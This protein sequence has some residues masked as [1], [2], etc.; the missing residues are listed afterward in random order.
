MAVE[1][2]QSLRLEKVCPYW[3]R[4]AQRPDGLILAYCSY[5]ASQRQK[6][7][8]QIWEGPTK[9]RRC[10]LGFRKADAINN[11]SIII[12]NPKGKRRITLEGLTQQV[13]DKLWSKLATA[14]NGSEENLSNIKKSL[15]RELHS[16]VTSEIT[17]QEPV[18]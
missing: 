18:W 15:V 9:S 1:H 12:Y 17:P 3:V 14:F 4:I 5:E 6:Q 2:E 11:P 16:S 7:E 8:D 10:L 13:T